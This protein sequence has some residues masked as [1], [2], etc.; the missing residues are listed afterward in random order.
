M[1]R[2]QFMRWPKCSRPKGFRYE[3]DRNRKKN[4]DLSGQRNGSVEGRDGVQA[5][6]RTSGSAGRH[7]TATALVRACAGRQPGW[8]AGRRQAAAQRR[9][10][11]DRHGAPRRRR[12]LF[13]KLADRAANARYRG[14]RCGAAD[15]RVADRSVSG[16]GIPELAQTTPTLTARLLIL[17][18]VLA[19]SVFSGL[20]ASGPLV[21]RPSN[22]AD[23]TPN[24]KQVLA[25]L[26]PARG[27]DGN[28]PDT[29]QRRSTTAA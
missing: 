14:N 7:A 23:L 6:A 18:L 8:I 3:P 4:N 17:G 27:K 2:A 5:A 24:E 12:S 1:A 28:Q 22:W 10:A 20:A 13:P 15:L 25:P 26:P 19:T 21:A 9:A 16:P 29:K 11:V